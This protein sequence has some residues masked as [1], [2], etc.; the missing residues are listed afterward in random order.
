[1][2]RPNILIIGAGHSGTRILLNTVATLGWNTGTLDEHGEDP[3]VWKLNDQ[4]GFDRVALQN[5][6]D[7]LPKPWVI[8]DTRLCH[9]LPEWLT[10]NLGKIFLLHITRD[11]DA[12]LRSHARRNENV[13]REHVITIQQQA[14][15]QFNN[16]SGPK[17]SIAFEQMISAIELFDIIRAKR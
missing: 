14:L 7:N 9:R 17:L 15:T 2:D 1:M 4:S 6:I 12:I 10:L 5:Y 8:K 16:F 11:V 13:D 3:F